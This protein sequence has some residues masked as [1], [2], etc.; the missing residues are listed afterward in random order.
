MNG[1]GRGR[2]EPALLRA[3][4]RA[5]Q[6]NTSAIAASPAPFGC[7]NN[8]IENPPQLESGLTP[9]TCSGVADE[10]YMSSDAGWQNAFS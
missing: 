5:P 2:I 10:C 9:A 7:E 4:R 8:I 6:A 3:C 1:G